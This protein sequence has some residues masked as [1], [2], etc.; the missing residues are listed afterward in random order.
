MTQPGPQQSEGNC[1]GLT[2]LY[3]QAQVADVMCSPSLLPL[4]FPN[5]LARDHVHIVLSNGYVAIWTRF[6]MSLR[7]TL[8]SCEENYLIASLLFV[9]WPALPHLAGVKGGWMLP[10]SA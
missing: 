1:G 3:E 8:G 9:L 10:I 2:A 4:N 6:R 5:P 7:I